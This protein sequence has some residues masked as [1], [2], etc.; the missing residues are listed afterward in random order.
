MTYLITN[1]ELPQTEA[2]VKDQTTEEVLQSLEGM[3][4]VNV[5]EYIR[6][7]HAMD[8]KKDPLAN[9]ISNSTILNK[10]REGH[11]KIVELN[12]GKFIDWNVYKNLPFKRYFQM[13]VHG[14]KVTNRRKATSK[15]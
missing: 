3:D 2:E 1:T 4:L 8:L 14:N 11:I 9:P 6:R 5:A 10:I 13:P 7:K 15:K 12:G